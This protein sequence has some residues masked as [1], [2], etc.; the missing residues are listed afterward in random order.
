MDVAVGDVLAVGEEI[1]YEYDFG[2]TSEL[3]VSVVDAGAYEVGP[4]SSSYSHSR[5]PPAMDLT[6]SASAPS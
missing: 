4:S 5:Y 6:A 1:T 2:T 3:S